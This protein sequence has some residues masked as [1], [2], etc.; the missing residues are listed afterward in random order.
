MD[1]TDLKYIII[2][3]DP[4]KRDTAMELMCNRFIGGKHHEG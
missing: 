1:G 2:N 4:L 3:L